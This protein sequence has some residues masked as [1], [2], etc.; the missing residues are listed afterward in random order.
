[1]ATIVSRGCKFHCPYCPIPGY[2]QYSFRWR[3]PERLAEEIAGIAERAGIVRFFGTDDNLFND[4]D[5]T[6]AIFSGLARGTVAGRPFRETITFASEA[7]EFDVFKNQDLLPLARDGGLRALWFGIEDITGSL[8]KKGQN[9]EKTKAVFKLLLDN[10]IA[11]M[12]MMMHHDGQPLWTWRGLSGLLNQIDF[13]FRAGAVTCQAT[14]LTPSV[15]SKSY[16]QSFRDGVVLKS[17]DGRPVEEYQYDGN[18]CVATAKPHPWRRQ[19]NMLA[20]YYAFY[21]R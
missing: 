4:R 7:T 8:V 15:G 5:A 20:S 9:A 16:E 18:H 19:F 3:S 6:E 21:N 1:M 14:L 17:V 11:P 13:L 10:G 2:N 12:P